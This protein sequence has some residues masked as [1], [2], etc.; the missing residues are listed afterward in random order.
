MTLSDRLKGDIEALLR[1][2][3]PEALELGDDG[4]VFTFAES[5]TGG[6]LASALTS[7]P[8]ASRVFPGSVVVY[9]NR[10]KRELLKVGSETLERYGAVS[11][12][13]AGEMALGA[14]VLMKTRL[15]VSVTGIAGPGGGSREKPVGTVWFALCRDERVTKIKKG[16]YAGHPRRTVRLHATRT[17]LRLLLEGLTE[18]RKRV[19]VDSPVPPRPLGDLV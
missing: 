8:G 15:A 9:G 16:L 12:Q 4:A 7:M 17:A 2:V 10:S 5:C 11:G 18:A 13:C 1:R 19:L 6:M 14:V 3:L